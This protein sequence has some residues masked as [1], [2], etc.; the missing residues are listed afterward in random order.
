MVD[1]GL[2]SALGI[3]SGNDNVTGSQSSVMHEINLKTKV[4]SSWDA[5]LML[6][7]LQYN[8]DRLLFANDYKQ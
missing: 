4:A 3:G 7:L 2:K 6:L 8:V 1:M 5:Y